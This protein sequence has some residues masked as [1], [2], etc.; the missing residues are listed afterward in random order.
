M[1]AKEKILLFSRDARTH[2]LFRKSW[3]LVMHQFG[4]D[5]RI[6]CRGFGPKNSFVSLA[7]FVANYRSCRIVFGTSEICLYS[8]FSRSKD[9]WVF[10]GL[11]RLLIQKGASSYGVRKLLRFMYRGQTLIVLNEADR[12]IIESI[13]GTRPF[14]IDGEGYV[15][16]SLVLK[17]ELNSVLTFAYIGRLLK[18]KCVDQLIE[19]FANHSRPDW[20]LILIG[21]TDFSNKDSV[22]LDYIRRVSRRSVGTIVAT[23]FQ[24][25]VGACLEGVDVL[26]SL[27][28]REGL[29]FSV[30]D[31]IDSGVHIVLSPVPGH[32]SFAGLPGV[33]FVEPVELGN[34][35]QQIP[36]NIDSMLVFDRAARL[37]ICKEKFGQETIVK[38]IKSILSKRLSLRE[39]NC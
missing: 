30:L 2:S 17:K 21:D 6:I 13:I 20:K 16:N 12:G 37:E 9:V 15:F 1:T 3:H 39:H 24:E 4:S 7:R 33:T 10:T 11:G 23:G 22:A 27:S 5:F 8:I 29:P 38:S 28:E 35:F 32:L 18:S 31:G 36:S 34:F 26:I 25:D 19:T 14:I